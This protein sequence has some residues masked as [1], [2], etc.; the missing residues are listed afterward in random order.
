MITDKETIE[1][2]RNVTHLQEVM[3]MVYSFSNDAYECLDN[4]E[5]DY[6][7]VVS[8]NYLNMAQNCFLEIVRIKYEKELEHYEIE[9]FF[10]AYDHYSFQL[11]QVITERDRNTSW[12]SGA[13]DSLGDNWK[14]SNEF[15]SNWIKTTMKH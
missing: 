2:L 11:R 1:M 10:Q 14:P 5:D 15:I 4:F 8:Q 6:K 7:Y 9:S 12:L 3:R 13:H